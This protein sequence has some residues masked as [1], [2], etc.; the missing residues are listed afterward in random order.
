M[1]S[2]P[3]S[4][5]SLAAPDRMNSAAGTWPVCTA[6]LISLALYSEPP[7][8]KVILSLPPVSWST[9]VANC[10]TFCVWKLLAL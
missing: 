10:C 1:E 3:N 8:C 6:R 2:T 5:F 9:S 7:G 4:G